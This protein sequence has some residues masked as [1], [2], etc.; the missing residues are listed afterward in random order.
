MLSECWQCR[1]NESLLRSQYK[2]NVCARLSAAIVLV[3]WMCQRN[4]PGT[5]QSNVRRHFTS[6]GSSVNDLREQGIY[7]SDFPTGA[8]Y[9]P[10]QF[11]KMQNCRST[12][13]SAISI[14]FSTECASYNGNHPIRY[15]TQC[16]GNRHNSRRGGDHI[17][18]RS[19]PPTWQMDAEM[20]TYMVEAIIRLFLYY[21]NL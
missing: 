11:I 14:C 8:F 18:H 1:G 12:E 21:I 9:W 17:V 13:K 10:A 2:H 4:T 3:H 6:N 5:S 16:H 20:Q 19:L 15:C 7:L